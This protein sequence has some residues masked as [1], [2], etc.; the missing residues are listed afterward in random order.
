MKEEITYNLTTQRSNSIC[1]SIYPKHFYI[2][3]QGTILKAGLV[4][5][6]LHYG[7]LV[8]GFKHLKTLRMNLLQNALTN[9]LLKAML[10][11]QIIFNEPRQ[12]MATEFIKRNDNCF[13]K[14]P[15]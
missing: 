9:F 14:T 11:L 12:K 6:H 3:L 5:K 8:Q 13:L 10:R 4:I 15:V 7:S 1:Q 2:I